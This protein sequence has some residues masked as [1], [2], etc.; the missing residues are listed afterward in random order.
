MSFKLW[1]VGR[2]L[3]FLV[4]NHEGTPTVHPHRHE[5]W[6]TNDTEREEESKRKRARRELMGRIDFSHGD[7]GADDRASYYVT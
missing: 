2:L 3:A 4:S 1:F 5:T 6:R 7:S